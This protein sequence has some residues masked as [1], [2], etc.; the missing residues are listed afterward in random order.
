MATTLAV[1]GLMGLSSAYSAGNVVKVEGEQGS[2]AYTFFKDTELKEPIAEYYGGG[3]Y[4]R[5]VENWVS[6]Y[7]LPLNNTKFEVT[8]QNVIP[9]GG[10]Y[11]VDR[12]PE[13]EETRERDVEEEFNLGNLEGKRVN[14]QEVRDFNPDYVIVSEIGRL[15]TLI[16]ES[17]QDGVVDENQVL[18][19]IRAEYVV[20]SQEYQLN[21]ELV[22]V[23]TLKAAYKSS[24]ERNSLSAQIHAINLD[25][26]SDAQG[27]A[28][29]YI[30]ENPNSLEGLI[31][32]EGESC[33]ADPGC[34]QFT[35]QEFEEATYRLALLET[36]AAYLADHMLS[37]DKFEA[38]KIAT[39]S[40]S[41]S[42][43]LDSTMRYIGWVIPANW[44]ATSR[45]EGTGEISSSDWRGVEDDVVEACRDEHVEKE[46]SGIFS[47]GDIVEYD[48]AGMF[49]CIVE[50]TQNM[51]NQMWGNNMQQAAEKLE[52]RERKEAEKKEEETEEDSE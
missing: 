21:K 5:G 15:P 42:S 39:T 17:G 40:G 33:I 47:S 27:L 44:F 13:K 18:S 20:G 52:E 35:P 25:R 49:D 19:T 22:P 30:R 37:E 4:A 1:T 38:F 8:D 6:E 2:P 28:T 3:N 14:Y 46:G 36:D 50:N 29:D 34:R 24:P 7:G 51:R 23:T 16:R 45:T 48:A 32:L 11:R 10:T 26:H 43:R 41:D 9:L 12:E 31:N